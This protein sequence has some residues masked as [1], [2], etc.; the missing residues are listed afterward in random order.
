LKEL[1]WLKEY[2]QGEEALCYLTINGEDVEMVAV[3]REKSCLILKLKETTFMQRV[4]FIEVTV[5]RNGEKHCIQETI[6]LA[7]FRGC[8]SEFFQ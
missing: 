1:P 4:I 7:Y 6:L 5:A 2:C 8:Y 3:K